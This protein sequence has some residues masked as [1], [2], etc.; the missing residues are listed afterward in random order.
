MFVCSS[1]DGRPFRLGSGANM[2]KVVRMDR[3]MTRVSKK[4]KVTI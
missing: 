1:S 4:L 3:E 2:E